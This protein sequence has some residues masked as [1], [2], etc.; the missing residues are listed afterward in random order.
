MIFLCYKFSSV[1]L[2][3]IEWTSSSSTL[4]PIVALGCRFVGTKEDLPVDH[5]PTIKSVRTFKISN[6]FQ[7]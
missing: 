6:Q 2:E 1:D 5:T 4:S 3:Q 7:S